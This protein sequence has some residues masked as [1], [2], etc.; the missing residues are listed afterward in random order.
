VKVNLPPYTSG[1]DA[2]PAKI[3]CD[4]P[5]YDLDKIVSTKFAASG[6]PAYALL[7]N[8]QWTNEDQNSVARSIAV[9]G[10]SDDEAAKKFID[11]HPQLVAK[12]L[13]GT[14]AETTA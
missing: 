9:D 2:D 7:K 12:W 8:F 5:K 4:Y 14:G 6:S 13:A 10:M 3:A 11:A 1:C